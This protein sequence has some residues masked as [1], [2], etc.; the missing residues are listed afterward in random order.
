[1]FGTRILWIELGS[2]L[3]GDPT[4]HGYLVR[5]LA[6]APSVR[7]RCGVSTRPLTPR[8]ARPCSLHV[9]SIQDSARHYHRETTEVYYIPEER[10]KIE[11]NG[12][13]PQVATG[14][15]DLD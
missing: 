4:S 9:T 1:M 11:L 2:A 12:E 8:T 14:N 3:D 6:D 15:N 7:V 13:W 5:K 10:A